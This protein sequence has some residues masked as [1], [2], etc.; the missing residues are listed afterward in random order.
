[1]K[2]QKFVINRKTR[3]KSSQMFATRKVMPLL[4]DECI[5]AFH[6]LYI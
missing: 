5:A 6:S 1:M 2:K 4:K 3:L